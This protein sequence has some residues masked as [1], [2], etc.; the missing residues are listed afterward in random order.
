MLHRKGPVCG[1]CKEGYPVLFH[2]ESFGCDK[3]SYGAVGLLFYILA[4]FFPLVL[5]FAIIMMMKLKL[6]SGL[7]Q[8]ILLFAQTITFINQTPS[9]IALSETSLY[10]SK[11]HSFL[12][13]FL[14]LRFFYVDKLSFCLWKGATVLR[15]LTFNYVTSL[16]VLLLLGLHILVVNNISFRT[17][18]K[19]EACFGKMTQFIKEKNLFNSTF[20]GIS[21]FLLLS[22]TQYTVTSFQILSKL[23]LNGGGEGKLGSVVR[24]QGNV[25]YFG[26]N[27]LP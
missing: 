9:L 5:V 10:F 12:L 2:S 26:P 19:A 15:N 4:E 16:S 14:S 11:I 24:L 18:W 25:D 3:C 8:S 1:E 6:T 20:H 27:H 23:T 17:H 22:Y 7:M 21:T 13:G